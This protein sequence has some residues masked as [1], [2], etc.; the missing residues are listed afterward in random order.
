LEG[1]PPDLQFKGRETII[2]QDI[3]FQR[4]TTEYTI[5]IWYSPS[6]VSVSFM[7]SEIN[8]PDDWDFTGVFPY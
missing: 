5:E 8:S 3:I 1:L 6:I 2:S 4:N 7:V